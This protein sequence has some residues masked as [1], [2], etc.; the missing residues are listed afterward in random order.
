M[1]SKSDVVA[2]YGLIH[3]GK[4]PA[5]VICK[6]RGLIEEDV[7]SKLPILY[8]EDVKDI[9]KDVLCVMLG[10]E[11]W[12]NDENKIIWQ[13]YTDSRDN[14]WFVTRRSGR[15][16]IDRIEKLFNGENN[17][18][19]KIKY[20]FS[21]CL[22]PEWGPLL[23]FLKINNIANLAIKIGDSILSNSLGLVSVDNSAMVGIARLPY[24][25]IEEVNCTKEKKVLETFKEYPFNFIIFP[26]THK[27]GEVYLT[28]FNQSLLDVSLSF[29]VEYLFALKELYSIYLRQVVVGTLPLLHNI[30]SFYRN[31]SFYWLHSLEKEHIRARISKIISIGIEVLN[32]MKFSQEIF[33]SV[34]QGRFYPF[35]VF[36][37]NKK[38]FILEWDNFDFDYPLFFDV[39]DYFFVSYFEEGM[40]LGRINQAVDNY[41][42]EII[43]FKNS[44]LC[45]RIFGEQIQNC[46]ISLILH[47]YLMTMKI[48]KKIQGGKL[49]SK[50][51]SGALFF[52]EK[53]WESIFRMRQF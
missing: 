15:K 50:Y 34:Y 32:K 18:F 31:F 22:Q 2:F 35:N 12:L 24:S 14:V 53:I 7:D 44:E 41:L 13:A 9:A 25:N 27:L 47:T 39:F 49:S 6:K 30:I 1:I 36:L 3:G 17:G 11:K 45:K 43:E 26:V 19:G 33:I 8:A 46:T 29:N 37:S 21:L 20:E 4:F 28:Y 48:I 40:K 52:L 42:R 5:V 38:V 51:T 16:V 23:D 10:D